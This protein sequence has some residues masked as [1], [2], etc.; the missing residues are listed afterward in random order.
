MDFFNKTA[1]RSSPRL[2]RGGGFTIIELLVSISILLLISVSVA[3]DLNR[4]RYQEELQGSARALVGMLRDLQTRALASTGAKTCTATGG[5][6]YACDYTSVGCLGA[7]TPLV[8]PYAY[9]LTLTLNAT[10]VPAFAEVE[11]TYNN[12][13]PIDL[14]DQHEQI[15]LLPFLKAASASNWVSI[16][17][18]D[19]QFFSNIAGAY[20]TFERQS[21]TMRISA[22][23]KPTPY[24]PACGPFGE[25]NT[26]T[27]TLRHS[28]TTLTKVIRLNGLTGKISID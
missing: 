2:K 15:D 7:C 26:L 12:R 10:S 6:L 3:T 11:P 4:T 14:G 22:C 16:S 8:P 1:K 5:V 18:I 28:K 27:I 23:A 25:P 20:V 17:R 19:D 21:G 13:R 24:T 9:G